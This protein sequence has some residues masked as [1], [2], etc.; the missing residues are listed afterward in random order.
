MSY[1]K[2]PASHQNV[3]LYY[4]LHGFGDVKVLFIMGLRTEGRAWKFQVRNNASDLRIYS[5][6]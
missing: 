6:F 3:K 1:L 4:E 5:F 2:L